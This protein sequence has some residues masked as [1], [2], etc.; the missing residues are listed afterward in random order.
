MSQD[1]RLAIALAEGASPALISLL[2]DLVACACPGLATGAA[3]LV[4]LL[5]GQNAGVVT[6]SA[7][8]APVLAASVTIDFPAAS[9]V[10]LTG[11]LTGGGAALG[12]GAFAG[13]RAQIDVD[14][15]FAGALVFGTANPAGESS[16]SVSQIVNVAPGV[17][18]FTLRFATTSAGFA[19]TVQIGDARLDVLAP[20]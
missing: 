6:D 17:H 20:V 4:F 9:S 2:R 16:A 12:G 7:G 8:G 14:G 10:L 15:V 19:Y 18:T 13:L 3:G 5:E 1:A 11:N